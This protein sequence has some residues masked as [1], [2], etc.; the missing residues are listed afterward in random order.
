MYIL[1]I[2]N[3]NYRPWKQ[4]SRPWQRVD[5]DGRSQRKYLDG[6]VIYGLPKTFQI[7]NTYCY[8]GTDMI[9]EDI[10]IGSKG[11]NYVKLKYKDP[12]QVIGW[13]LASDD[14]S[15]IELR[16]LAN[17]GID[18]AM[19]NESK[20]GGYTWQIVEQKIGKDWG[21]VTGRMKSTSPN[22]EC[23]SRDESHTYKTSSVSERAV[24]EA[25]LRL[26]ETAAKNKIP[27][28]KDRQNAFLYSL[29]DP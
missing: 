28:A 23:I 29:M 25:D 26:Q 6:F 13:D 12:K 7:G 22:I 8:C 11:E 2:P 4:G 27:I 16:V 10:V 14:F 5:N 17:Y 18:A 1:Q 21:S 3:P 24:F 9:I 19:L 20:D 15:S